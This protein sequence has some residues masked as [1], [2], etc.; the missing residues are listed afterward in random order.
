MT[1]RLPNVLALF[2]LV[3]CVGVVAVGVRSYVRGDQFAWNQPRPKARGTVLSA[4]TNRGVLYLVRYDESFAGQLPA[5]FA[6]AGDFSFRHTSSRAYNLGDAPAGPLGFGYRD[7]ERTR[8]LPDP[9]G[10][11]HTQRWRTLAFPLWVPAV[12]LGLLPTVWL[13]RRRQLRRIHLRRSLNL[14]RACGYDLRA[15][16]DQCPECGAVA[17][18]RAAS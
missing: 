15:T 2:S 14:C 10:V 18:A 5:G 4:S 1:R 12:A 11:Q 13:W 8:T 16:P 3:L 9:P 7:G 17:A 6:E